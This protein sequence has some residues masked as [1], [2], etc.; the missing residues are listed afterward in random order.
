MPHTWCNLDHS[1]GNLHI[2]IVHMREVWQD[3]PNW[4]DEMRP[5]V[6]NRQELHM[7]PLTSHP[8]FGFHHGSF[9]IAIP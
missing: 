4:F 7:S 9:R 8:N 3:V 6:D 5:D 2:E 1:A